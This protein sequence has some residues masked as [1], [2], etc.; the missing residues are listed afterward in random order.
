MSEGAERKPPKDEY[1]GRGR[2]E[3]G[4]LGRL[5][6][7]VLPHKFLLFVAL[8]LFLNIIKALDITIRLC[9]ISSIGILAFFIFSKCEVQVMVVK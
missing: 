1:E 8:P 6:R 3:R 7:L 5:F 2:F 4:L 9:S